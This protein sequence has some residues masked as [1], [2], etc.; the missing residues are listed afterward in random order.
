M[1]CVLKPFSTCKKA[2]RALSEPVPWHR[3]R[4][5]ATME[6]AAGIA[7]W[8]SPARGRKVAAA[9][10]PT[11]FGRLANAT[12]RP[13]QGR[14]RGQ[15]LASPPAAARA[16]NLDTGTLPRPASR[17]P[18]GPRRLRPTL[19]LRSRGGS[20]RARGRPEGAARGPRR[21]PA[22]GPRPGPLTPP[23]TRREPPHTTPGPARASA[24]TTSPGPGRAL[25]ERREEGGRRVPPR[26][27]AACGQ[28]QEAGRAGQALAQPRS[29]PGPGRWHPFTATLP[30]A[31]GWASRG[32]PP[33]A[34]SIS[35]GRGQVVPLPGPGAG[36]RTAGGRRVPAYLRQRLP[37]EA[38]RRAPE[39]DPL[40]SFGS[41]WRRHL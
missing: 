14:R 11:T 19:P 10:A 34:P 41:V 31:R 7:W 26:A 28:P 13:E 5:G 22:L 9:F 30:R 20:G 4:P 32:L 24:A 2:A 8:A 3:E 6:P 25:A 12:L 16:W 27:V 35:F 36:A 1:S 17:A 39:N 18:L 29:E 40:P 38:R 37:G 23:G 33:G 15:A 21:R